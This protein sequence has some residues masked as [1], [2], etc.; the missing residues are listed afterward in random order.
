MAIEEI[1][2][3]AQKRS[4]NLQDVP[5]S[6][7]AFSEQALEVPRI[8]G[9]ADIAAATPNFTYSAFAGNT[10]SSTAV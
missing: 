8:S 9:I 7:T 2:V 10:P 1:I 5:L 3:T 6:I 4:E